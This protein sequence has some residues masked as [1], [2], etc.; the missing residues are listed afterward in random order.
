MYIIGSVSIFMST[1][2][3][4]NHLIFS[5]DSRS[6]PSPV[7]SNEVAIS[8]QPPWTA[9]SFWLKRIFIVVVVIISL[10]SAHIIRYSA[11]VGDVGPS[12]T[13]PNC[14]FVVLLTGPDY[15]GGKRFLD[16][17]QI[18]LRTTRDDT[19]LA[20]YHTGEFSPGISEAFEAMKEDY[21]LKFHYWS[22][23]EPKIHF[24]NLNRNIQ[25]YKIAKSLKMIRL[26]LP[27]AIWI[28]VFLFL[29]S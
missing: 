27:D 14:T 24:G 22:A 19:C 17:F 15:S 23:S 11:A 2:I 26:D 18:Y 4:F 25:R 9:L 3:Y 20:Y 7:P 1:L 8:E 6:L 16:T 29:N 13:T 12:N 21:P 28:M 10:M 5:S